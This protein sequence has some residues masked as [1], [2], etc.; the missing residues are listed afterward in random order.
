[1]PKSSLNVL[2]TDRE[3][4]AAKAPTGSRRDYRIKGAPS[5]QLRVTDKGTKSWCIVYKRLLTGTWAKFVFGEYPSIPMGEAKEQAEALN[6]KIRSGFDPILDKHRVAALGTFKELAAIYVREHGDRNS[7]NGRRSRSTEEAQRIL[8]KDVLPVIGK[9]RAEMIKKTHVAQVA[10]AVAERGAYVAADRTLALVRAIFNWACSSGRLDGNPTLGLKR[11]SAAR[12][13]TRVLS[14]EEIRKFWRASE[15]MPGMSVPTRDAL[16]LQLLTALRINEVTEASRCEIDL[17]NKLW[18][19]PAH[20]TKARRELV[21]PLSE[22]AARLLATI[23]AREDCNAERRSHRYGTESKAPELLFPTHMRVD[24]RA[25]PSKPLKWQ[26]RVPGAL[27]P[28]APPRSLVR[29]REQLKK[30]G[31]TEPF[32][33]HDLRRSVATHLGDLGVA[34]DIV[35]RILNHAPR[36]VAG[37]HYNHAKY[38]PQMRVALDTWGAHLQSILR[39]PVYQS[40]DEVA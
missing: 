25:R 30:A 16:R 15:N 7:R 21:L 6:V 20:R 29:C 11:R 8:N 26:R 27:D 12:A 38:L 35:E 40:T 34:D 31:I 10:E 18:T 9:M 23:I 39:D 5:L 36:T 2:G 28:H 33:T 32:N 37:K 13:K 1:M 3:L 4:K 22:L 14:G 24:P 17:E 19:I